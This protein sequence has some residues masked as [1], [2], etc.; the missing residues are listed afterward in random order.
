M[1][2]GFDPV[3]LGGNF[4][5]STYTTELVKSLAQQFPENQYL[6]PTYLE[7]GKISQSIFK[8]QPSVGILPI[9]PNP[10]MLGNP[11]KKKLT[12][13]GKSIELKTAKKHY[14]LYHCTNPLLFNDCGK[15]SI[16]T[17]HDLIPM[18]NEPSWADSR[19]RNFYR[20]N[21]ADILKKC[22]KIIADSEYTKKVLIEFFPWSADRIVAIPLSAAP[23]FTKRQCTRNSLDKYP[24]FNSGKS[25]IL[26]VGVFSERKNIPFLLDSFVALPKSL[27][28]GINIVLTGN[29]PKNKLY[30]P[31]LAR[32][33]KN[34][35]EKQVFLVHNIP[36]EDLIALYNNAL[37]L[38]FPSLYEGFGLPLLEAMSCGCPVISSNATSLPEVGEDAALYFDPRSQESCS[39][40]L[41]KLIASKEI[42]KTMAEKGLQQAEKFS[43]H[44]TAKFTFKTYRDLF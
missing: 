34:N 37:C 1:K 18:I 15:P 38:V 14:D 32:I 23:Q 42:Q 17:I 5:N 2:I 11:F 9:I 43:W 21:C 12:A 13:L 40:V 36:Q 25:F 41:E 24:F 28:E 26:S 16:I 27:R 4:G 3:Q 6:I 19:E 10:K 30:P 20:E 44:E 33:K 31:I 7:R 22:T 39:S 35:L 8:G 29:R